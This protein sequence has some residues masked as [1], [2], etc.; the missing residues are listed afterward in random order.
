MTPADSSTALPPDNASQQHQQQQQ[1]GDKG[2]SMHVS[3][4]RYELGP[5]LK[6]VCH[7]YVRQKCSSCI[8]VAHIGVPA[9]PDDRRI[10]PRCAPCVQACSVGFDSCILASPNVDPTV[11]LRR[12]MPL[13]APSASFAVF[14]NWMQPLADCMFK[15][16]VTCTHVST[17][18]CL[19]SASC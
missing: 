17:V 10:F 1:Q 12:V 9:L 8:E 11:L 3:E 2:S 19:C 13:L 18:N 7:C 14:S 15:L 6:Q 5:E 16:Q 4:A